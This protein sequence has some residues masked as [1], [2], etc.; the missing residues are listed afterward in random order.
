MFGVVGIVIG[1]VVGVVLFS[2]INVLS[3]GVFEVERFEICF[4]SLS[5]MMEGF[6]SS[7]DMLEWL[8][9]E[10]IEKFGY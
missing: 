4:D 5:G 9:D 6:N 7:S 8:M 3:D 2:L 1:I 10:L